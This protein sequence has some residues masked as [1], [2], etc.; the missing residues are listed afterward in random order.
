MNDQK[1]LWVG[2]GCLGGCL[3]S[4]LIFALF[5]VG[6]IAWLINL[7][8]EDVELTLEHPIQ[9]SN[10]DEVT[11]EIEIKNTADVPQQLNSIDFSMN[12]LEGLVI[13]EADP[14]FGS[15]NLYDSFAPTESFMTYY[16]D[17][18]IPAG[19]SLLV[20]FSATAVME[21]DFSGQI[22]VCVN[23][24]MECLEKSARTVIGQ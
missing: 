24:P 4:F 1:L 9:V 15:T 18:T 3:L 13:D 11:I 14:Q 8:P 22:T 2:G 21:G 6:G 20:R 12:Y 7:P 23:S 16:F 17:Q 19:G 10:G 5:S